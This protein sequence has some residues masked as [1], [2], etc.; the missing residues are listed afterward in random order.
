MLK[1]FLHTDRLSSVATSDLQLYLQRC[2]GRGQLNLPFFLTSLFDS[3]VII[4][5]CLT[6]D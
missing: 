6:Q 4:E 3:F 5:A 1:S 2:I